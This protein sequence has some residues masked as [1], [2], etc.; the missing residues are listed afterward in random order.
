MLQPAHVSSQSLERTQPTMAMLP[1]SMGGM[2]TR[3][4]GIRLSP[5]VSAD[6]VSPTSAPHPAK[7]FAAARDIWA[8]V[9]TA[10][11]Y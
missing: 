7:I 11:L 6:R 10:K 3:G 9:L 8:A 5:G 2:L 4:I 1:G